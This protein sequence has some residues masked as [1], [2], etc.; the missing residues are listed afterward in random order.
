MA[1]H[2]LVLL[3]CCIVCMVSGRRV[4]GTQ[5]RP[6]EDYNSVYSELGSELHHD[7]HTGVVNQENALPTLLLASAPALHQR[8]V[9]PRTVPSNDGLRSPAEVSLGKVSRGEDVS[10]MTK[11]DISDIDIMDYD[12]PTAESSPELLNARHSAAHVLAMAVKRFRPD[13]ECVAGSLSENGFNYDF[14]VAGDALTDKDLNAI[15]KTMTNL[16]KKDFPVIVQSITRE[17]AKEKIAA[18]GCPHKLEILESISTDQIS[19]CSIDDWW[20]FCGPHVEST[21]QID[22]SAIELQTVSGAYLGGDENNVMLTRISATAWENQLQLKVFK[23]RMEEAVRRDH[24]TIGQKLDLFSIQQDAGGGLVFWHPKGSKIRRIIQD[25][26]KESHAAAGYEFVDTPHVADLGLWKTSGHHD[27]YNDDMFKPMDVEG[28]EYQ[29]KP[30]NCPFHCL[31]YKNAPKSYRDLPLRWAEMGTV[32]RYEMSGSLSGLFRVRGFTQDDAHLF[33][34]PE[35]LE[36]EIVGVLDLTE[37]T[38]KKFGFT[39]FE[40]MLST[41]PDDAVG[42]DEIWEKATTALTAALERKGWDYAIDEGGGAFYGPKID[43]KIK[44]AIGRKWQLSTVQ[45]DFNLPE[46]FDM[47][48]TDNEG[49]KKRPIMVHRAIFGSIERFFGIMIESTAGDFAFWLAPTQLKLLP[50]TEASVDYCYEIK[51]AAE[52]LR[53]RVEV[54]PYGSL[55][56]GIKL[57]TNERVPVIGIVGQKEMDDNTITLRGRKVGE[58]G[59]YDMQE[60]LRLMKIAADDNVELPEVEGISLPEKE[61]VAA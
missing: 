46:R 17:E 30:M 59:T 1:I 51:K 45:C 27:F 58:L 60:A 43:F 49:G 44:D 61:P 57:A 25:F 29:L 6:P 47:V 28:A 53:L 15:K 38:L 54:A 52:K 50:V 14:Y 37:K 23:K 22:A 4:Q 36:D 33:L 26:W 34:L 21:K 40:A 31:I 19:I 56:K 42:S 8:A 5:S 11:V 48:Y 10:M 35:Q 9:G 13:V 18:D 12:L 32:Y 7:L 55:S 20:D 3:V 2:L 24:R 39:K 41:R 16:I